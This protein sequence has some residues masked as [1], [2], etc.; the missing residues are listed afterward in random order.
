M[1][2]PR[3]EVAARPAYRINK[4]LWGLR[5]VQIIFAIVIVG[6]TGSNMSDWHN[7]QPGGCN[8]PPNLSFNFAIGILSLL[9]LT[10]F[11]FSTGPY[12][13]LRWWH[14]YAQIALEGLFVVLWIVAAAI[15]DYN[16]DSVCSSCS[17]LGR[18]VDIGFGFW[19]EVN[20]L[21]CIC[22]FSDDDVSFRRD[23]PSHIFR[24]T[25]SKPTGKPGS[26]GSRP[27]TSKQLSNTLEKGITTATKKG[28]DAAMILLFLISL[29][30]FLALKY[31]NREQ[32]EAQEEGQGN[33]EQAHEQVENAIEMG[34]HV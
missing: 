14:F 11:I 32:A 8:S 34:Q 18:E 3:N 20:S 24:R 5:F 15:A 16:C 23:A 13:R 22:A 28:L 12:I 31:T 10:Y 30:T 6:I 9:L 25:G 17:A 7:L 1:P 26:S 21:F 4:Y 29:A 27:S 19:V 33:G 2:P